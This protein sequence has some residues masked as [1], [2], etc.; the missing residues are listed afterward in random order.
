MSHTVSPSSNK[1]YG[2]ARVVGIW[3]LARSSF[4]AARRPGQQ[5]REARWRNHKPP[6]RPLHWSSPLAARHATSH[7]KFSL[8]AASRHYASAGA[9][10]TWSA[11][12]VLG[13]LVGQ[14]LMLVALAAVAPL[15]AVGSA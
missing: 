10:V 6:G 13:F 2:V 9:A 15:S 7:K 5:R 11:R 1:P 12:I 4:Y 8:A 14:L 3:G